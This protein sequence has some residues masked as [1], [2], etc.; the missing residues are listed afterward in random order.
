MGPCTCEY[1]VWRRAYTGKPSVLTSR[2]ANAALGNSVQ[3]HPTTSWAVTGFGPTI[4]SPLPTHFGTWNMSSTTCPVSSSASASLPASPS[5][6][7][8][9][10]SLP[11]RTAPLA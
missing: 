1:E 5:R 8:L 10:P 9:A 4:P 11:G 7:S 2:P 3:Q 6:P